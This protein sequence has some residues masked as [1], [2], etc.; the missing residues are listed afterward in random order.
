MRFVFRVRGAMHK[1]VS[2]FPAGIAG[3]GTT[4]EAEQETRAQ[5]DRRGHVF[6]D[7]CRRR[8]IRSEPVLYGAIG[9]DGLG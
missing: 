9:G 8:G 5:A 6:G 2:R 3:V 7:V 4:R 1:R